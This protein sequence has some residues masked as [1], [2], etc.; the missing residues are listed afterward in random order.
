MA[1]EISL[2]KNEKAG[3]GNQPLVVYLSAAV[4]LVSLAGYLFIGYYNSRITGRVMALD[5]EISNNKSG[6][7]SSLEEKVRLTQKKIIDFS[8][9]IENRVFTSNIS[10]FFEKTVHPKVY[11]TAF[12]A[13][14]KTATVVL[15][16]KAADFES[17][18][19]QLILFKE[20][21]GLNRLEVDNVSLE[22][23]G[24]ISFK[25][26]LYFKEDFFRRWP[27]TN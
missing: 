23:E 1:I 12:D 15:G 9:L 8:S 3:I 24:G 14:I 20:E 19:Q 22:K 18:G 7:I 5:R 2:K 27:K 4:F 25:A 21:G 26:N 17:L 6:Q 11:F 10:Q 16:G 13:D